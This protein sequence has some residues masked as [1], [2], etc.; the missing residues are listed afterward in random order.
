MSKEKLEMEMWLAKYK[1]FKVLNPHAGIYVCLRCIHYRKTCP[2]PRLFLH[3]I[4]NK[5]FKG[6]EWTS[7][8]E[9]KLCMEW[10]KHV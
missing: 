4:R 6:N 3:L 2:D 1:L 10:I 8:I 9:S 5:L 7:K